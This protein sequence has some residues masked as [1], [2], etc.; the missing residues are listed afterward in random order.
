MTD[1]IHTEPKLRWT[2][3]MAFMAFFHFVIY[4]WKVETI[5]SDILIFDAFVI[6]IWGIGSNGR[7]TIVDAVRAWVGGKK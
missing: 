3:L 1:P 7:A 2:R 4:T 5:N 6:L